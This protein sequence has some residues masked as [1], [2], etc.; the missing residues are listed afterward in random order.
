MAQAYYLGKVLNSREAITE[1]LLSFFER[2][3]GGI[4]FLTGAGRFI[5]LLLKSAII[6]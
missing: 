6:I 3:R 2:H 1:L 5:R 4:T